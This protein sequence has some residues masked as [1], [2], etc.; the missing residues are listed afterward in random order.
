MFEFGVLLND[1]IEIE[2][3]RIRKLEQ[4]RLWMKM[5]KQVEM[6]VKVEKSS[7]EQRG[8]FTF[9]FFV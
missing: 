7:V 2:I 8:D 4:D 6:T 1:V 3:I 9:L 5:T